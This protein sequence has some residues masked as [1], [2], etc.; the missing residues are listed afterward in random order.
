MLGEVDMIRIIAALSALAMLV[1]GCAK[2]VAG[3]AVLNEAAVRE[4][5]GPLTAKQALGDFSSINY[6]SLLESSPLPADFGPVVKEPRRYFDFCTFRVRTDKDEVEVRVGY[7]DDSDTI[8]GIDHTDDRTRTPPRGLTVQ[9]GHEDDDGCERFLRFVDDLWLTV[10]AAPDSAKGDWCRIT[11]AAVDG[12]IRRVTAQ[13]VKHFSFVE[14]SLGKLEACDLVPAA[15]VASK[16][17]IAK[18]KALRYP[19]GH[20]CE[21]SGSGPDD[22]VVTLYLG[23]EPSSDVPDAEEETL[24]GRLTSIV[25]AEPEDEFSFCELETEHIHSP[26]LGDKERVVLAIDLS[27]A[28]KDAC[29]PGRELAKEV[30]AKL[31]AK[32]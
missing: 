25:S 19:A 26:D 5:N 20:T 11:D 16:V 1:A 13:Q 27:G 14:M 15:V 31:P 23:A 30:W 2:T 12:V 28:G 29:G 21:W 24:A 32:G 9:R 10:A 17:G 6:C 7:L 8:E 22:P 18:P 4:A 3:S